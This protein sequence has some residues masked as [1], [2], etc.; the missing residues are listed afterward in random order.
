M[1]DILKNTYK[2][3]VPATK[4]ERLEKLKEL[5]D[6]VK[7]IWENFLSSDKDL[8]EK[9]TEI[10]K[11]K[12]SERLE[13]EKKESEEKEKEEKFIKS[14]LKKFDDKIKNLIDNRNKLINIRKKLFTTVKNSNRIINSQNFKKIGDILKNTYKTFVP[15][16]KIGRL[17]K[18]K[19][20]TEKTEI[21]R[22]SKNQKI[23]DINNKIKNTLESKKSKSEKIKKQLEEEKLKV[24]DFDEI[25]LRKNIYKKIE[26]KYKEAQE[27][28]KI[29]TVKINGKFYTISRNV[30][31]KID[32]LIESIMIKKTPTRTGSDEDFE[33]VFNE[34]NPDDIEFVMY[35]KK[36][37]K[38]D[39]GSFFNYINTTK[40]DLS[41][42][43]IY[44]EKQIKELKEV[45]NCLVHALK[46]N[47]VEESKLNKLKTTIKNHKNQDTL[48]ISN[49][50]ILKRNLKTIAAY[51]DI[52]IVVTDIGDNLNTRKT[53][54]GQKN[55][56]EVRIA[57]FK[58]HY[59][60]D[61]NLPITWYAASNY[62]S[63]KDKT[64]FPYLVKEGNRIRKRLNSAN[65]SSIKIVRELYNQGYFQRSSLLS[66]FEQSRYND[67]SEKY[68]LD[69]LENESVKCENKGKGKFP[70]NYY[71]ADSECLVEDVRNHKPFMIGYCNMDSDEVIIKK[72]VYEFLDSVLEDS[73]NKIMKRCGGNE[74]K[75]NKLLPSST[76]IYF[77][78]L[79][80]DY[81][82]LFG[83]IP[84]LT[85]LTKSG[86]IY[87]AVLCP[88]Y[89][90]GHKLLAMNVEL[91]DSYK[92]INIPLD[93]FKKAYD[94][95]VGKES[96]FM[97]Y[98]LYTEDNIVMPFVPFEQ[99]EN[100]KTKYQKYNHKEHW[101]TVKPFIKELKGK[102]YF[103]HM[104]FYRKYLKYD[105]LT[106]KH[107]FLKYREYMEKLTGID[108]F[109]YLTISAVVDKFYKNKGV[110]DGVYEIK[111]NLRQFVMAAMIGGRVSTR[112]RDCS[113]EELLTK[114]DDIKGKISD[115]DAVSLYP[116][117]MARISGF[118]V[119]IPK[120]IKNLDEVKN[121]APFYVAEIIIK[122]VNKKQQIPFISYKKDGKRLYDDNVENLRCVVDK[123]TL[124][125]Y[126]K[127]Q[128]I[129]FEFVQGIYWEKV[130]PKIKEVIVELFN[131]RLE[132]KRL[133][134]E[135]GDSKYDIK[136]NMLKLI[137]N[138]SYGKTLMKESPTKTVFR[139]E[140]DFENFLAK[141][142]NNV[143]SFEK[144][145]K[146]YR[147]TLKNITY[148]HVN[149]A[150]CGVSILSMSKRIM[151]EVMGLANDEKIP[152][153]YQ[154]TD[155]MHL[156]YDNVPVLGYK[157][158]EKYNR[159]L[160]GKGLGQFHNDLELNN[161]PAWS[162]RCIVLGKKAYLDVVENENGDKGHHIRMKGV[163]SRCLLANYNNPVEIYEKLRDGEQV[164][165]DLTL[166]KIKFDTR[167]GN[168]VRT[169]DKF[170]RMVKF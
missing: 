147:I 162:N 90:L 58:N 62:E 73:Y 123:V 102:L 165:F 75:A 131:E 67:V 57:L 120:L 49:D 72:N 18:L 133:L 94:L 61:I 98:N 42:L 95:K 150:H 28:D 24:D 23:K 163:G 158:K 5:R 142:Y 146:E 159:D 112:F 53:Y 119:G 137:M 122:K 44:N 115:F 39:S 33:F 26:Q 170:I 140:S 14:K 86:Q 152:I 169:K 70:R 106:L 161:L 69:D 59:F 4:E 37:N 91:R 63:V 87:R 38:S 12:K 97:P 30:L 13:K 74:E 168:Y 47:G 151:N 111:G 78:N 43:Q 88:K 20:L 164:P 35:S 138:S 105:C 128:E 79:K 1:G 157:F 32:E 21:L 145:Y 127:F 149:R 9:I 143:I 107:G 41:E 129:E 134:K 54:Y 65:C 46:L 110:Y 135:T 114:L 126:I 116:S 55:N 103:R 71:F 113:T 101:E 2:V 76:V 68:F 84:K 99:I 50:Y 31:N 109:Q 40:L 60:A 144:Y 130:N 66:R 34:L 141:N 10:I 108:V 36:K 77:H 45:D 16:T 100:Y 153:Y 166:G 104:D 89:K 7:K 96:T 25:L 117:A 93:N 64:N 139:R 155:S 124:E 136:Q 132:A 19:K 27:L 51:L 29:L 22:K 15:S 125:D 167:L 48:E 52:R 148:G 121:S 118:P 11:K 6:R 3:F 17:N 92:H 156:D 56:K 83:K 8:R 160:I 85:E 81:S 82:V 154:D 80:Y